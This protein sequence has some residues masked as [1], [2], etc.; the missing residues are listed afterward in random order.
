MPRDFRDLSRRLELEQPRFR[1]SL[2]PVVSVNM[3]DALGSTLRE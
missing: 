3:F 2:A 1:D